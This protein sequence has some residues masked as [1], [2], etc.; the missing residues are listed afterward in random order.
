MNDDGGVLAG[1]DDLVEIADRAMAHGQGQRAVVPDRAGW[2]EQIASGKVGGGHVLMRRDRDQGL[3]QAEGHVLDEAGLAAA[4]RP[5]Q[6]HRQAL[7]VGR[8]EDLYFVAERLIIGLS[9]DPVGLECHDVAPRKTKE[10][11]S[12]GR[13]PLSLHEWVWQSLPENTLRHRSVRAGAGSAPRDELERESGAKTRSNSADAALM[14]ICPCNPVITAWP[15]TF[16]PTIRTSAWFA[17]L[18]CSINDRHAAPHI[19][20]GAGTARRKF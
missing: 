14:L 16:L 13:A 11:C 20:C 3:G 7:V 5:L 12:R 18:V 15:G 6:H 1:F 19:G 9:G 17:T 10:Q 4:G 2:V 8:G